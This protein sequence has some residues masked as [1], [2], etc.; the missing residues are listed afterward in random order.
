MYLKFSLHE[1]I[2]FKYGIR[3]EMI[4]KKANNLVKK[5]STSLK[6]YF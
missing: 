6:V 2:F 4:L 3:I 1:Y 5:L